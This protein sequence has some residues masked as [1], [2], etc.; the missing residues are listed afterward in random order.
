VA[1]L[2]AGS[3]EDFWVGT[4]RQE[5]GCEVE[6]KT[7]KQPSFDELLK[8]YGFNKDERDSIKRLTYEWLEQKRQP[9]QFRSFQYIVITELLEELKEV[10]K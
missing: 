9:Y 4:T 7:L 5:D 1:T 8:N 6:M 2:L 3:L 10:K